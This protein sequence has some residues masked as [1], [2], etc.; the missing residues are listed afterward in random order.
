MMKML[1]TI[2]PGITLLIAIFA[3][4]ILWTI[5]YLLVELFDCNHVICNKFSYLIYISMFLIIVGLSVKLFVPGY[6]CPDGCAEQGS[7]LR[8]ISGNR[9]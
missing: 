1:K 8:P 2:S 7:N 5:K 6:Y 9:A 4:G 3:I